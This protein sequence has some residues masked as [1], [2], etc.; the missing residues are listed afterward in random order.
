MRQLTPQFHE[1]S[2]IAVWGKVGS[3]TY[4]WG[5]SFGEFLWNTT[6][7]GGNSALSLAIM[8]TSVASDVV[9][10]SK[11]KGLT[12][13]QAFSLG[14]IAGLAEIITEK[15]SIDALLKGKWEKSTL[16]FIL[17]NMFTEGSEEVGSDVINLVADILIAKDKSEW[18]KRID[19]YKSTGKIEKAFALAVRDQA[20][21]MGLD[22]VGGSLSGGL[23]SG[24]RFMLVSE[25]EHN[26]QADINKSQGKII[27][28]GGDSSVRAM[29]SAWC[30]T[31]ICLRE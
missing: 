13:T 19:A 1:K 7:T 30:W 23:A 6:V 8:G 31:R 24:G 17:K 26:K 3:T 4:N 2:K 21:Q 20:L 27:K 25:I 9:I 12:D 5:L 29:V 15:F 22:F 10:E 18:Q 11:D 16:Q 14:T 28:T